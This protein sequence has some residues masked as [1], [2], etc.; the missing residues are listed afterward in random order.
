MEI[1]KDFKFN[2]FSYSK[3]M[4]IICFNEVFKWLKNMNLNVLSGSFCLYGSFYCIFF[5]FFINL[6]FL[7]FYFKFGFIR[8]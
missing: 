5:N 2:I 3:R 7:M 8:R 4:L 1:L 6:I